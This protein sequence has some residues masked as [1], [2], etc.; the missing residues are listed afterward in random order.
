MGQDAPAFLGQSY[1]SVTGDGRIR[2]PKHVLR[3]L[4]AHQVTALWLC[5]IPGQKAKQRYP[6]LGTPEGVR[7]YLSPSTLIAFDHRGRIAIPERLREHADLRAGRVA[8]VAG[9]ETHFEV[10]SQT[11]FDRVVAASDAALR[12]AIDGRN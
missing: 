3:Q 4:E 7:A 9:M 5:A 8:V 11:E 1:A 10:W 2:L 12:Q 6:C